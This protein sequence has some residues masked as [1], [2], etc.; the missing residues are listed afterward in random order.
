M[1]KISEFS[2]KNRRW[3]DRGICALEGGKCFGYT[4]ECG[5]AEDFDDCNPIDQIDDLD[6][7]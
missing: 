7:Y 2:K 1:D 5:E 4:Y 6:Y 3:Y